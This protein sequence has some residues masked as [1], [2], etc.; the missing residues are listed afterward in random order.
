MLTPVPPTSVLLLPDTLPTIP[1]LPPVME[2]PDPPAL[3]TVVPALAPK[4]VAAAEPALMVSFGAAKTE[5]DLVV[6][7]VL[8]PLEVSATAEAPGRTLSRHRCH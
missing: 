6:V 4:S 7:I 8:P 3:K 1:P 2:L 5:V